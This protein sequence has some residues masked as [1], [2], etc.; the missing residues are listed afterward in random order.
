MPTCRWTR[1]RCRGWALANG[2]SGK[3]PEKLA[4]YVRDIKS[5][6]RPRAK[7]M[8]KPGFVDRM[9]ERATVNGADDKNE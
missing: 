1:T 5:G 9:R 4:R 3:N 8:L 6:K 2:W 7:R